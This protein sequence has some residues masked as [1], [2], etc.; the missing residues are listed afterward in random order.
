MERSYCMAY[1]HR[2]FGARQSQ[3]TTAPASA[4]AAIPSFRFDDFRLVHAEAGASAAALDL[5]LDLVVDGRPMSAL[6]PSGLLAMALGGR[7]LGLVDLIQLPQADAALIAEHLLSDLVMVLERLIGASLSLQGL[8]QI[9]VASGQAGSAE[10]SPIQACLERDGVLFPFVLLAPAHRPL[11]LKIAAILGS[12]PA[13]AGPAPI[14]RLY[15]DA[16]IPSEAPVAATLALGPL[17]MP[18]GS[19][20]DLAAGDLLAIDAAN[21]TGAIL[22]ESGAIPV[23]IAAEVATVMAAFQTRTDANDP[24]DT[25]WI[26]LSPLQLGPDRPIAG[27]SVPFRFDPAGRVALIRDSDHRT[28]ATGRL[29][30]ADG[31][32]SFSCLSVEGA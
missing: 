4:V 11:R 29:V 13:S 1:Q 18:R 15:P 24:V 10:D 8:S 12:R 31:I 20:N 27:Q 6:M 28:V 14:V 3:A 2:K 23:R 26:T 7:S 25:F 5:R 22:S 17:T 32:V 30:E 9:K 16:T 21:A 19:L